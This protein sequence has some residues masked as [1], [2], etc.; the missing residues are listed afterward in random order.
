MSIHAV[1]CVFVRVLHRP[2]EITAESRR[3]LTVK[4]QAVADEAFGKLAIK[5]GSQ[6]FTNVVPFKNGP[7]VLSRLEAVQEQL[8]VVS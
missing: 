5:I 2:I 6:R 4:M 1:F 7:S 8:T 3:W